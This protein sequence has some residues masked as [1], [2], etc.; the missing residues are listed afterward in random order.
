[1]ATETSTRE[2]LVIDIN[3]S[4]DEG[5]GSEDDKSPEEEFSKF[6]L[7]YVIFS[8]TDATVLQNV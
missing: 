3:P 6:D 4:D 8:L 1:M 2:P 5:N 7:Y